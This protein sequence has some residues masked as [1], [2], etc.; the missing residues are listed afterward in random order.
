MNILEKARAL[1]ERKRKIIFWVLLII[2]SILLLFFWVKR[3]K[4][5]SEQF[6]IK[7]IEREISLPSFEGI[8]F[9]EIE[10]EEDLKKLEEL[11]EEEKQ[12]NGEE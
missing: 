11:I 7:E 9:P 12:K 1:P 4:K 8:E 2:F 3:V 5:K 10:I 6:K